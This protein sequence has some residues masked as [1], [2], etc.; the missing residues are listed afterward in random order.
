MIRTCALLLTA[1]LAAA[2]SPRPNV[3]VILADDLGYGDVHVLNP[4]SRIPTPNFDALAEQGMTFTDSH[5]PSAVCTPTRY[6]LLTGTYCWR[7]R[8]KSGVL[9]GYSTPLLEP[10]QPTLATLLK[11]AGYRTAAVGKW[12][13]GMQLPKLA[14]DADTSTWAGDPGIDFAGVISDGPT[15]H[16]FD[17]YFGVSAS[18][19]MAPYVYIQDDHFAAQPTAQQKA[20]GFPAFVRQGP[21]SIDFRIE[22]VL[23]DLTREAVAF[24]EDAS[25]GEAP[26]F[27]YMPL[28]APHKPT[29]PHDHFRDRTGLGE[30]GDFI[31]QV[32][33]SIGR[34]LKALEDTGA[35]AETLVVVTSDNGS[36][37]YQLDD[38]ATD[39]VTV[40]TA[41]GY[42]PDHHRPNGPWRGT[43]ADVYE[44]GHRVPFFVRW[45][46]V[47]E[48]GTTC[49][50]PICHVDLFA[51]FAALL[52]QPV[53][54]GAARDSYSLLSLLR[55][56]D[57]AKRGGAVVHHSVNGTFALREGRW[58]AVF[59]TG[60]G[61]RQ[62]PKGK[63][64]DGTRLFDLQAD[65]GEDRDLAAERPE[66]VERMTRA[67]E[68]LR[69]R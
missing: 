18:L 11:G 17:H 9:G 35:A 41:H 4:Q 69:A 32:D 57:N 42:H 36:Y 50:E 65:P 26:F 45:P 16:G 7:S 10:D 61:G 49:A 38:R 5:S 40:P 14:E 15:H 64:F 24:I 31:V 62:N 46:S 54:E 47:V 25:K 21:R 1:S 6:G 56:P 29:L 66:V 22:N 27:L 30:Y 8:L 2:Q 48:P 58:K 34:V 55:D 39:H 51:T 53:P 23:D 19:D 44:A 12:H 43:K 67:L 37:M 28:T 13:L 60:S 20:Q 52:E 68:A 59:S 33:W 3:V 63:P